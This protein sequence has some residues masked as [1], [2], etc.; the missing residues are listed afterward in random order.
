MNEPKAFEVVY[1]NSPK[2]VALRGRW[3][4]T[5]YDQSGTVKSVHE[6]NNIVTTI[7]KQYIASF[8]VSAAAAA[9]TFNCGFIA[10]GTSQTP[11]TVADTAMN[12]ELVRQT[13][14]VAYAANTIF[15]S[16]STFSA[17]VGTGNIY[18]YGL[19]SSLTTGTLFAH[20]TQPLIAKGA[21]DVL[22]VVAQIT[23]S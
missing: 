8:L 9:S 20:L 16:T 15:Q 17:G 4:A 2:S 5:L 19:F 10:I 6:T 14:T 22:I 1:E 12:T 23:L 13:G 18:E 7:G 21:S 3:R 11:E